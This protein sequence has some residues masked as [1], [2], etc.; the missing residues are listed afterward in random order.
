LKLC[1]YS[2]LPYFDHN[3][4]T[5]VAP[6]VAQALA[7]AAEIYGNPSS[8]HRA[9]Q[10]ARRS[11]ENSRRVAAGYLGATPA[12][13]VFTSGGTEANNLAILGLVRNLPGDRK[14][15][16]TTEIEHPAVHEPC[17]QL[18]REG[19]NVTYLPVNRE[20]SVDA[21]AVRACVRPDTVLISVM[22]A[23]NETGTIQPVSEIAALVRKLQAGG[24]QVYFHSDGVQTLGKIATRMDELG[25]HLYAVSAHKVFAPK[26][27]GALYVRKGTPLSGLQLGGRHERERRAGTENVPG[28]LAFARALELCAIDDA[29][30]APIRDRFE[31]H[32]L[33]AGL[34]V[35]VNG[36]RAARLPNTSNLMFPGVSGEAMVIAL[37]MLDMAVSS[38][39]ACSSGS[40]EPS[41]VL[42]AMGLSREEARA[43]VRFSFGRYNTAEEADALA[44]AV[45]ATATRLRKRSRP[46]VADFVKA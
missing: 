36:S 5:P 28:I 6:E 20:G 30:V 7:A 9:G 14:H 32:V 46:E 22:H 39:A 34:P 27:V 3:A 35:R 17:R 42:L 4:T 10:L 19:V 43:S 26:G 18:A 16:I 21:A 25:M 12:E 44:G 11:L 31:Q 13:I 40:I 29:K 37:D 1:R 15:V 24:Q 38:G 33:A 41:H 23:N 45:I 8:I 2:L